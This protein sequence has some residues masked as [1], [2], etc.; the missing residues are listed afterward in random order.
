LVLKD[1]NFDMVEGANLHITHD[2]D[3]IPQYFFE[4]IGGIEKI[5]TAEAWNE[6]AP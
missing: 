5:I 1:G 2:A 3:A 6:I 4:F